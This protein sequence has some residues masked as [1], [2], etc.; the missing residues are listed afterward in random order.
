MQALLDRLPRLTVAEAN[1]F[2]RWSLLILPR[3][4]VW[5]QWFNTT[6]IGPVPLSYRWRGRNPNEIHQLNP[7]TLSSGKCLRVSL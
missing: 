1:E 4:H 2:R 5:Y 3:L 6:Q 7:L